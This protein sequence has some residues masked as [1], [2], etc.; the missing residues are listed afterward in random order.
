MQIFNENEIKF[1]IPSTLLISGPSSSGKTTFLLKLIEESKYLFNP[2]PSNIFYAY[3]QYHKD[4]TYLQRKGVRVFA[5]VPDETLVDSL[6][7]YTILIFD[8]LMI[9]MPEEF[10]SSLFTRKSHHQKLACIFLTQNLFDKKLKVARNNS[11]YI[12]LMNSPSAL[13]SIRNLG[14]QLFP[15]NLSYFLDAY[16][17]ACQKRFGYLLIDLSPYSDQSLR[18]RT[19][20]FKDDEKIIFLPN[21][22]S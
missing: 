21:S 4:V 1:K 7:P 3:G 2:N 19:N 10:L 17:K 18:L 6:P 12:V 20:I 16:K 15:K 11:H 9:N 14:S 5:G 8:D 22:R 13:L